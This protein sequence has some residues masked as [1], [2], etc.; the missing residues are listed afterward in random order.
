MAEASG[1]SLHA[2]VA[3]R[4]GERKKLEHLARYVARA[5][6]ATERLA[7]TDGGHIRYALKA[8][9]RD[10]TMHVIFEPTDFIARLAALVPE[11]RAHLTRYHGAF[12]PHSKIRAQVTPGGRRARLT[13]PKGD[14]RT[15]AQRH[16]SMTWMQR[17]KRVFAIGIESCR[18]C[19]GTLTVS[20]SIEA[21]AVIDRILGHLERGAD[22]GHPA[23]PTRAPP[24][25]VLP[26]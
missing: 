2:G 21:R 4:G 26:I 6:V 1:F 22:T 18:R 13:A 24:Q 20:A 23:H 3:A 10:G 17:L 16:R 25:G 15:A 5:P 7:L 11:P 12:A 14:G 8:P 19:D 9:Y